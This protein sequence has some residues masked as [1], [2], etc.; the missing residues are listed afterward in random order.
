ML[1]LKS[2]LSSSVEGPGNDKITAAAYMG[3]NSTIEDDLEDP[4]DGV[5]MGENLDLII[6]ACLLPFFPSCFPQINR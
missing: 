3:L 2:L 5:I 1:A 6:F 4:E